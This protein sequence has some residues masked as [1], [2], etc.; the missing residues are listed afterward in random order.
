[1][2][3][4]PYTNGQPGTPTTYTYGYDVHG[5]VSQLVDP[6]GNTTASYGYT[7]Y[8]QSDGQLS[9]GDT[10]QTSPLNPFRYTGKRMDTGSGTLDMGCAA[11]GPTSPTS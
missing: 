5:S 9:Q 3:A 1:M 11:L 4:T 8:G 2:T 7:P 10:N 6:S